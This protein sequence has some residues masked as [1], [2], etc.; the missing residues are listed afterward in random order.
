MFQLKDQGYM[1][2]PNHNK[3]LFQKKMMN[4]YQKNNEMNYKELRTFVDDIF[5]PVLMNKINN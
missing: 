3:Y 2:I 5:F 4:F 1:I